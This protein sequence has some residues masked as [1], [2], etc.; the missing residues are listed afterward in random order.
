MD[1]LFLDANVMF[2]AA[3]RAENGLLRL[4]RLEA[5]EILTSR[6]AL[7]EARRNLPETEQRERLESLLGSM[8][9]IEHSGQSPIESEQ[10][11]PEKDRPILR[12]AVQSSATHLITGDITHFGRFFGT[13][14]EGVRILSPGAYLKQR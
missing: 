4:W 5:I 10:Q 3:Y 2:S 11:L 9:I 13:T 6:Y 7:E 8:R 12:A 14:V 1:R